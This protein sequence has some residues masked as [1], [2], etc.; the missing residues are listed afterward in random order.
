MKYPVLRTKGNSNYP[1]KEHVHVLTTKGIV[2]LSGRNCMN[3]NG[4]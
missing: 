3:G 1:I 4:K 2:L